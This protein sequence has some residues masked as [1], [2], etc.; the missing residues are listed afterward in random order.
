MACA[1]LDTV[2]LTM[3]GSNSKT[4]ELRTFISGV[5]LQKD[6]LKGVSA[7]KTKLLNKVEFR[8]ICKF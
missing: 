7:S 1:K 8:N 3:D 5:L 4:Y 6:E 2:S